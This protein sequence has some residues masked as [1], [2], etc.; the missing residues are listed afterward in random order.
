VIINKTTHEI[1]YTGTYYYLAHFSKFV[2]PGAIRVQTTGR[3][4]GLRVM[5]FLT[6]DGGIVAQVLNSNRSDAPIS[7]LHRG[8]TL[9]MTA[10]ALSISTVLW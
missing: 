10:P 7:L 1:T 9:Q 2:R 3:A 5:S 4:Q 6:P 8:H